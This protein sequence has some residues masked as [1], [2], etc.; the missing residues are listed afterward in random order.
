M[1]GSVL[2]CSPPRVDRSAA[3]LTFCL[4]ACIV[5][6]ATR[7]SVQRLPFGTPPNVPS[8]SRTSLSTATCV[9]TDTIM[10]YRFLRGLPVLVLHGRAFLGLVLLGSRRRPLRSVAGHVY[11]ALFRSV[12]VDRFRLVNHFFMGF[13]LPVRGKISCCSRV[14][15]VVFAVYNGVCS[16]FCS[17]I[18][19]FI[20]NLSYG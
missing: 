5:S 16:S 1:S 7:G 9:R 6:R 2:T 8:M 18:R 10:T 15:L 17:L 13:Y 11:G 12:H 4:D 14:C 19:A 3:G 20:D